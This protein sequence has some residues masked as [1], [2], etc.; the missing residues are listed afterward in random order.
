M[1]ILWIYDSRSLYH[2][3]KQTTMPAWL[4]FLAVLGAWVRPSKEAM[5]LLYCGDLQVG[6]VTYASLLQGCVDTKA[7]VE[8]KW[9]H[10]HMI[11][12]GLEPNV[13]VENNLINMYAKCGSVNDVH[14]VF[15]KM[16]ACDNVL[17]VLLPKSMSVIIF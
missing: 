3:Q 14:Q 5:K 13:F 6:Y 11:K 12:S 15:N 4:T 10:T 8:G 7:L 9:I 2:P 17:T 16:Y 1:F